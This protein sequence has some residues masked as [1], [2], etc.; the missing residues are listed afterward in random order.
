MSEPAT[1]TADETSDG[2]DDPLLDAAAAVLE[3][4]RA[5]ADREGADIGFQSWGH[6]LD[7]A[8]RA[9]HALALLGEEAAS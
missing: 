9:L 2:E 1:M 8:V 6:A 3:A 4:A 5:T 7:T